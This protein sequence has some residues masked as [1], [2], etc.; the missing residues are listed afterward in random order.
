[1]IEGF[2]VVGEDADFHST[3]G[4]FENMT[5]KPWVGDGEHAQVQR[6]F[7]LV[8]QVDNDF[9]NVGSRAEI[10]FVEA[11]GVFFNQAETVFQPKESLSSVLVIV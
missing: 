3:P 10:N 1:M 7:C 9:K 11:E 6:T 5:G 2:S 8:K 4:R